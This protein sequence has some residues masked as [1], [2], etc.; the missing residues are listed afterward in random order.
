MARGFLSARID[1]TNRLH[2]LWNNNGTWWIHYTVNFD[3]RTRRVR[4]S[5]GT[6]DIVVAIV[7]RDELL[8]RLQTVGEEVPERTPPRPAEAKPS[9]HPTPRCCAPR[10]SWS[11]QRTCID[12]RASA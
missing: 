5:L 7:R 2:H 10:R 6:Q 12:T 1:E 3:F 9:R 11:E 8:T 4:R